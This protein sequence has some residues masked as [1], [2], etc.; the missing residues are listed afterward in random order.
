[1]KGFIVVN[2]N[3]STDLFTIEIG[4][5]YESNVDKF[6]FYEELDDLLYDNNFLHTSE[7]DR[8]FEVE[9]IGEVSYPIAKIIHYW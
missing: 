4:K 6:R 7:F 9:V 3:C 5:V 2:R 8:V 1:M